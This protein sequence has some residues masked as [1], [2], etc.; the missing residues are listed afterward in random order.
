[1]RLTSR[2]VTTAATPARDVAEEAVELRARDGYKLAAMLFRR[3]GQRDAPDVVVFNAGGGLSSARY[4]NFV[5]FLAEEGFPTLAY[6]YRGV[7]RSRP[8]KLRG[9]VAGLED[10]AEYDQAG[11]IDYLR[12]LQPQARISSVSHSIGALVACAAPNAGELAQMVFIG[13]H[14]G[15]WRDYAT[16][17][18]W[19]MT[20]MW[21]LAMPAVSHL[22]GYF[23]G[24]SI[25]L[26]D[27]FPLRFALQWAGRR[28]AEF[29]LDL[30]TP[31]GA[32]G[33][34]ALERAAALSIPC[35]AISISDD[36]FA[37]ETGVRRFLFALPRVSVVRGEIDAK[38][39]GR[40]R[41]GHFGFFS[42]RHAALWPMVSRF[43]APLPATIL[44]GV[45]PEPTVAQ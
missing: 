11:A 36:P 15:Y 21:H 39:L 3:R 28:R 31:D 26:G 22:V 7:G 35:M 1:M 12:A 38:A 30:A 16:A 18:K 13:P 34:A 4:H 43:L 45:K 9:F 25:G 42:R 32:R 44:A 29:A 37:G 6:D 10:W 40:G 27:D 24:R 20:F 8:A 2:I 19:P 33:K 14:T 41:I 5:R 17:W 23:P